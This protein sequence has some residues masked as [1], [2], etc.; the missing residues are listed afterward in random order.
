VATIEVRVDDL[1]FFDGE[2]IVRPATAELHATTALLRRLDEAAGPGLAR[3]LRVQA[4]LA[5]G[6]AVVTGAGAL[7]AQLLVHAVVSSDEEAVSTRSVRRALQSALERAGDWA[8]ATLAVP[9]LGLGAG[10]LDIEDSATV[11]ADVIAQHR[12]RGAAHPERIVLVAEDEDEASILRD[13]LTR[14]G[15]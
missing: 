12:A 8:I 5:V 10:N 14:Q 6:S 7:D 13:A 9:P 3:Q 2:A 1:A 11:M 15:A 4:P